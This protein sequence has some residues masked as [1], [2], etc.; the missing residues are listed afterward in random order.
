MKIIVV[1]DEISSLSIFLS[2]VVNNNDIEYKFFMS[3]PKMAIDYVRL[4][5]VD[6]AFLDINM[7]EIDGVSLAHALLKENPAIKIVFIT[8]YAPDVEALQKDF[9]PALLGFAY[10]PYDSDLLNAFIQKIYYHSAKP[11]ITI[12]TFGAF[13]IFVNDVPLRFSSTKSK[14]LLALLVAKEGS[15]VTMDDAICNLWPDKDVD[16]AKRL[17]RDAVWRLRSALSNSGI[18]FLVTFKRALLFI[19]TE[20]IS[21]DYWDYTHHHHGHYAGEFMSGYDWSMEYQCQLDEIH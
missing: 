2:H 13:D 6:G 1:D 7:P 4:N 18:S 15:S 21:C 3:H 20:G 17:Y 14:E 12:K 10:K 8:G 16:L 19:Q 5:A 9:G 11:K